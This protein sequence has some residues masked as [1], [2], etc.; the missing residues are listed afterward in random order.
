MDILAWALW[1]LFTLALLSLAL[2][3]GVGALCVRPLRW[4]AALFIAAQSEIDRRVAYVARSPRADHLAAARL[5]GRPPAHQHNLDERADA[6]LDALTVMTD[7]FDRTQLKNRLQKIR[8]G[9]QKSALDRQLRLVARI[10][11]LRI[12]TYLWIAGR[13]LNE[14]GFVLYGLIWFLPRSLPLSQKPAGETQ[15]QREHRRS[16][17]R[18]SAGR[19]HERDAA[20]RVLV[21]VARG[22]GRRRRL[23]PT[24]RTCQ[25]R[26]G[27]LSK[28]SGSSLR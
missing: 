11:S 6:I 18:N 14:A 22:R 16:H 8:E 7:D 4:E 17:S 27:A 20:G 21:R 28:L 5:L 19:V 15:C 3:V 23:V 2:I 24:H 25:R 26:R 1:P 10:P 12:A 9:L 13:H